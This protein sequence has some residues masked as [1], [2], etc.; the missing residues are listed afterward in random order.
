ML[1]AGRSGTIRVFAAHTYPQQT[2]GWRETLGWRRSGEHLVEAEYQVD[3]QG[4]DHQLEVPGHFL[5]RF[6]LALRLRRL[7]G[8]EIA[9]ARGT[10]TLRR[11]RRRRPVL[12]AVLTP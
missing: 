7:R 6:R 10:P 12:A 3:D 5:A 11:H 4:D 8:F 9:A 2:L 1:L